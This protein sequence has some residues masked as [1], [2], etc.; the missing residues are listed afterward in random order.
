MKKTL[1]ATLAAFVVTASSFAFTPSDHAAALAPMKLVPTK[2]V[3]PTHLPRSFKQG[4][5]TIEFSLDRRGR[6]QQIEV[7]SDTDRAVREQVEKAFAQWKFDP[8]AASVAK[9][10]VLPLEVIVPQS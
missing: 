6:P 3:N 1:L 8:Q 5:I 4:V 9:R 7:V 10:F 2:V